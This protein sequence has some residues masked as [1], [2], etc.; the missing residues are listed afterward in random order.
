MKYNRQH[1]KECIRS[2]WFD[3]LPR[4]NDH[5]FEQTFLKM[6]IVKSFVLKLADVIS[7]AALT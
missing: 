4:C 7:M 5:Q 6:T 1:A 2:D 3:P